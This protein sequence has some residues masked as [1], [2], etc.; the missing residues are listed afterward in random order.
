MDNSFKQVLSNLLKIASGGNA[1]KAER[2]AETFAEEYNTAFDADIQAEYD[3]Q[4]ASREAYFYRMTGVKIVR[5]T[6]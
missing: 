2:E 3:R 6:N 1:G 5:S 4:Q